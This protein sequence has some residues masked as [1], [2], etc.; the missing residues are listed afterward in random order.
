[1]SLVSKCGLSI[2]LLVILWSSGRAQDDI[3]KIDI[4]LVTVNVAVTDLKGRPILDLKANDF[5]V[6]DAEKPVPLQFFDAR[7]PTS[8]VFVVDISSS[9]KGRKWWNL[10]AEMK[11]F[12]A[13]AGEG[14]DYT[15][16]VFNEKPRLIASL[17]TADELWEDFKQ[18]EP[19]GNTAL[20]DGLLM[21]L[22]ALDKVRQRHKAL[23]LL[24]DGQDNSS[25]S[26][27]SDVQRES[28]RHRAT[29]YTVGILLHPNNLTAYE[30]S[31]RDLLN[32]LAAETGGLVR[33]PAH[34]DIRQVLET[35]DKDLRTQYCL[36]YY[37]SDKAPGWRKIQVELTQASLGRK[38]RYQQRY[39]LK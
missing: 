14:N 30:Q 35:I 1:M 24:S 22:N 3:V 29:I 39:E 23:V 37:P 26:N 4:S 36:S 17:V 19:A 9:M 5:R 7:G 27:I 10:A 15:L 2:F 6:T 28:F 18:I 33:Y 31:G 11:T 12:L 34:D 38:L 20:Y 32:K 8:V 25:D 21:G 16:I 13:N